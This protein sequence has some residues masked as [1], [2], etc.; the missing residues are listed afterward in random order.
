MGLIWM[1]TSI[2]CPPHSQ[3]S[4]GQTRPDK[5]IYMIGRYHH[6][7]IH[8]S[9]DRLPQLPTPWKLKPSQCKKTKDR[10]HRLPL[11]INHPSAGQD[12]I[13]CTCTYEKASKTVHTYIA[14]NSIIAYHSNS[15]VTKNK[16]NTYTYIHT[17]PIL[18]Y[19][20]CSLPPSILQ[21]RW[22]RNFSLS[23]K[24]KRLA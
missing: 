2:P 6:H 4:G 24:G 15:I 16:S 17:Y 19:P 12:R 20:I 3:R 9:I 23:K 22:N 21:D 1:H 11:S 18:S 7:L 13:K 14:C 5:S 8:T 10:S